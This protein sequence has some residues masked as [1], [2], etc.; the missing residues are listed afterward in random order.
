MSRRALRRGLAMAGALALAG[1][2]HQ[3][4]AAAP[5]ASPPPAGEVVVQ[6]LRGSDQ[7][8]D[9]PAPWVRW[10]GEPMAWRG[11]LPSTGFGSGPKA[12]EV[13]F[14]ASGVL[15]VGQGQRPTSGHGVELATPLA[16]VEGRTA[17][18]R[19]VLR[20]PATGAITAQ[21]VTSP[22]LA[23]R[24]PRQGLEEVRAV[25]QEGRLLGSARVR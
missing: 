5:P 12:I 14:A 15:L 10:I 23:V 13:D 25:D 8:G 22:C 7:C 2:A 6:A 9:T 3:E 18:V 17:V 24:V 19:V 1:C 16:R 21:V 11:A 4:A 20:A